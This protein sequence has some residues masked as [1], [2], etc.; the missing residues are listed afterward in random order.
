MLLDVKHVKKVYTTRFGGNS[1][2]ALKDVTFS[3]DEGEY[4]AVMGGK[5]FR[6]NDALNILAALDKPTEGEVIMNGEISWKFLNAQWRRLDEVNWDSYFRI[7]ICWIL[8]RSKTTYF[9]LWFCP[10]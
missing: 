1:V 8:F 10:V 9:C 6:E 3:V 2:T 7:L 4:V 5:W